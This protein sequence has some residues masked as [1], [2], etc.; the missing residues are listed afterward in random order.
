MLDITEIYKVLKKPIVALSFHKAKSDLYRNVKEKFT[1]SVAKEKLRLL[2]KL[3][4]S[5]KLKLHTDHSVFVRSAGI[6]DDESK[7]LLNKFTLQGTVPEPVKVA[8]LFAKSLAAFC[9]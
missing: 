5:N 9:H 1:P 2:E 3:G 7:I 4:D 6:N 8:R